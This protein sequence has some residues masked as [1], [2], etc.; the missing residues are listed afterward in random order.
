M[1]RRLHRRPTAGCLLRGLPVRRSTRRTLRCRWCSQGRRRL[2]Y[3]GEFDVGVGVAVVRRGENHADVSSM[4]VRSSQFYAVCVFYGERRTRGCLVFGWLAQRHAR[5]CA[6]MGCRAAGVV[7]LPHTPG[8]AAAALISMCCHRSA[9]AARIGRCLG[10]SSAPF[11][12][13]SG[14]RKRQVRS[15]G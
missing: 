8:N 5:A 1:G 6:P 9:A 11:R 2:E 7:S 10:S 4:F 12:R 15:S 13:P 3:C 14:P